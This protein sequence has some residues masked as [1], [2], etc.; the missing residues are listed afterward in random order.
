MKFLLYLLPL[1]VLGCNSADSSSVKKEDGHLYLRTYMWTG[2]YGSNLDISWIFLSEDGKIVRNP[3]HGVNPVQWEK[4]TQDNAANT[5]HYTEENGKLAISWSN[6]KTASWGIEKKDGKLTIIDGGI[7]SEPDAMPEH[8]RIEGQYA[9]A[10]VLPNVANTQTLV[11]QKDGS[12]TM[13][14]LGTVTTADVAA[15]SQNDKMG[16]YDITGNTLRFKF[17]N[18]EE[19]KSVICIWDMDGQKNLVINS[20]YYPQEK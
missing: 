19:K 6:G 18:G 2:M 7:V 20:R 1:F 8:Y 12:F 15:S 14:N 10:T 5:G 17:T 11:F 3:T 16:T 9:A 13:N 4:E